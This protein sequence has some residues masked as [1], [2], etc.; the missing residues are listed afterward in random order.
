MAKK[1]EIAPPTEAQII[2]AATNAAIAVIESE[3][4]QEKSLNCTDTDTA[5]NYAPDMETFGDDS[6]KLICKASSQKQGWMKTTKAMDVNGSSVIV[7]T[8]TQQRNP[9]GSWAL[10]QAVVFVQRCSILDVLDV[11]GKL[12]TRRLIYK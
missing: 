3:K 8:E 1:E 12:V 10:S 2:V 7:Q 5:H 6:W 4:Q 9:D 11:D